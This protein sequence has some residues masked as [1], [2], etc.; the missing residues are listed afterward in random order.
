MPLILLM[1]RYGM[2]GRLIV[3]ALVAGFLLT[4]GM[5]AV[6]FARVKLNY[7]VLYA[8]GLPARWMFWRRASFSSKSGEV[9]RFN[10]RLAEKQKLKNDEALHA[11]YV[12]AGG[13]RVL[14]SMMPKRHPLADLA[15]P[16]PSFERQGG[17]VFID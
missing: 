9:M 4:M 11:Y 13:R 12:E 1:G 8:E 16:S 6:L 2:A 3:L 5:R 17:T 14:L 15:E 7:R 10:H